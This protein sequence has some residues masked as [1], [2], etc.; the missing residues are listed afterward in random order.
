VPITLQL[1]EAYRKYGDTKV[2]HLS[3]SRPIPKSSVVD[4]EG[5]YNRP[6]EIEKASLHSDVDINIPESGTV[7][8]NVFALVIGNEHYRMQQGTDV[9]FAGN[10][11]AIF[12][13]YLTKTLG[14]PDNNIRLL[15]D[16]SKA[17]METEIDHLCRLAETYSK[18]KAEI[19][20]YY[21]GHGLC[22]NEKSSYL[23]PVDVIGTQVNK[24]IRL[25][26]VYQQFGNLEGVKVTAFV[27]AC[28][29]GGARSGT[30]V[31]ARGISVEPKKDAI[32]GQ[33]VVFTAA[34]G[35]E[36]AHPWEEQ[37]HGMFTYYLLKKIQET[38][39]KVSY[40]ELSEY[41]QNAVLHQALKIKYTQQTPKV[42][43]SYEL[44]NSWEKWMIR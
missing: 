12:K 18:G 23:I 13:E 20:F 32:S 16:A 35:S 36:T 41:V 44:E 5:E 3:L 43:S 33:L 10:D 26:E 15:T 7:R 28:F 24:G 19:I 21:A 22:D 17:Q 6:K 29:S 34:S 38:S 14:V 42:L 40:G 30:L 11:A 9:S 1:T 27:D 25:D 8:S 37:Q 4:V 2:E 39:G 31:A